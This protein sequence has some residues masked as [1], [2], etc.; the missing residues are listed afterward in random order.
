MGEGPMSPVDSTIEASVTLVQGVSMN[1][2]VPIVIKWAMDSSVVV[3]GPKSFPSAVNY[4]LRLKA[5][6]DPT[7]N[8]ANSYILIE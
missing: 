2:N 1:I 4:T 5:H 3:Q 8:V 7:K 6:K